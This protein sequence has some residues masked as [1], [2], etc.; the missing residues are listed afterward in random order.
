[1]PKASGLEKNFVSRVDGGAGALDGPPLL[2]GPPLI[3]SFGTCEV[4][5]LASS[6]LRAD[7]MRRNSQ[8]EVMVRCEGSTNGLRLKSPPVSVIRKLNASSPVRWPA[9]LWMIWPS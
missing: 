2:G 1:V 9:S 3:G 7:S 5:S 8:E 4:G 6:C